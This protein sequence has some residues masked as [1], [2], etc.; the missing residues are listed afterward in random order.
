MET[1]I[2]AET[3]LQQLSLTYLKH[4]LQ[5]LLHDISGFSLYM[6]TQ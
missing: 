1:Q 5:H 3:T 2:F 4:I 6:L